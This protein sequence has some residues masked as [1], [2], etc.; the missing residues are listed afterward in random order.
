[1]AEVSKQYPQ[2]WGTRP[3]MC[4]TRCTM[5]TISV[6]ISPED[7][8]V[9]RQAARARRC[10]IAQLIRDAMAFYRLE[11][12][13]QA[14]PLMELPTLPGH[15]P[16]GPVPSRAEIYAEIFADAEGSGP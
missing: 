1:M 2:V 15:R 10:S 6:A 5:K 4:Y 16:R 11:K 13:Q 8:E 7:Y 9:F 3:A 14:T 12:L